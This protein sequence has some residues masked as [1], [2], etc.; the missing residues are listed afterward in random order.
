[1]IRNRIPP[2]RADIV[3]IDKDAGTF[4][5]TYTDQTFKVMYH[6]LSALEQ[7]CEKISFFKLPKILSSNLEEYKITQE[8]IP[9]LI[10]IRLLISRPEL[11]EKLLFRIGA[12]LAEAHQKLDLKEIT[13][14]ELPAPFCDMNGTKT[15]LHLDFNTVNVQ[16]NEATD[17]IYFL[18]WEMTPLLK[19]DANYGSIYYD[20]IH[21]VYQLYINEPYFLSKPKMKNTFVNTFIKGYEHIYGKLNKKDFYKAGIIYF[22][23]FESFD[24]KVWWKHFLK[25][26][27]IKNFK[28]FL[29]Q[30]K[31]N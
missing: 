22:K 6:K 30:L 5:K 11:L 19:S 23:I 10:P 7:I 1:M 14:E 25:S 27:N 21:M 2:I 4:E 29:R 16:Y 26:N 8:Y 18:D 28:L 17:T 31:N 9:D 15:F 3:H 24:K 20:I 12:G 13:K